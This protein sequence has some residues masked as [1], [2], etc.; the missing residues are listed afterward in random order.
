MPVASAGARTRTLSFAERELIGVLRA[1][2][3]GVRAVARELGR[4]PATI[5]RELRRVRLPKGHSVRVGYRASVAQADAD[6]KARRPKPAKLATN[7]PLRREV[8]DRLGKNHSPEQIAARL[9]EDFPD[10]PEMWVSHETIYQSL[11]VQARGGLK[12]ELVKHLRTGR[13]TRKPRYTGEKRR[14]RLP[15]MVNISER[16]KQVED[17]AVPGDWEG[18]LILGSLASGSAIATMVERVTGFTMLLHMSGDRSA[19]S[20]AAAMV[21][22]IPQLPEL[23]RRSLTWDQGSEMAKHVEIAGATG[24]KIYFCDPHSP[25]QRAI[26]ENTNG[27]LRQYF[28]KG[29]DLSQWGPGYLDL[30]ASEL[31]ARPRKRL[32]WRTPAEELERLLSEQSDPPGVA[33]TG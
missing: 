12:R 4:D 1:A 5:S 7:L 23:L 19:E 31:N 8:Q 18:D 28:P 27:L 6:V 24:L 15:N 26:N 9:R 10:D 25:W 3:M 33:S 21:A 20:V 13:G 11:Y 17:R 29:T 22:K 2:G 32:G 16:P 30:V 14:G